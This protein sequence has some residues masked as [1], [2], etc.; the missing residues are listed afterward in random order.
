[1]QNLRTPGAMLRL[2]P[3]LPN[4]FGLSLQDIP[5]RPLSAPPTP[6]PMLPGGPNFTANPNQADYFSSKKI[7]GGH[8]GASSYLDGLLLSNGGMQAAGIMA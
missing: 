3:S 2:S 1:M 8:H 7:T 6:S 5:V 4:T